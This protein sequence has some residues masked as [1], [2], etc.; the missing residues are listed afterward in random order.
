MIGDKKVLYSAVQATGNLTIGNYFGALR[1]WVSLCD[2]YECFFAVANEHSITVRQ[3]P[4][5]LR[6]FAREVLMLFIA[7]GLDPEKNCDETDLSGV[8]E[9]LYIKV[10]E[11][12]QVADRMK[13]V[14][15]A[16]LQRVDFSEQHWIDK[17]IIP[18]RL[19]VPMESLFR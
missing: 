12:G 17:P 19:A 16:F 1:N 13:Y 14:R 4:A 15:A 5:Q 2:E 18:N 7:S 3:E 10:E 6:K 11:N 9:G 8:M